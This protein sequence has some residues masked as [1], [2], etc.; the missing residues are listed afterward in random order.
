MEFRI[1]L[2]MQPDQV[3]SRRR[4]PGSP[5][6]WSAPFSFDPSAIPIGSGARFKPICTR[7]NSI[8]PMLAMRRLSTCVGQRRTTG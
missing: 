3:R 7:N 2:G 1:A 5:S 4:S 8:E 6:V